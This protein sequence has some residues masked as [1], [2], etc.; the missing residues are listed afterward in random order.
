VEKYCRAEQAT[1]E[2]MAHA[3]CVLDTKKK[4]KN[5]LRIR[6]AT[7]KFGEFDHKKSFLP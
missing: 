7:Q 4:K 2:N 6:G 1:D 5:K 3:H